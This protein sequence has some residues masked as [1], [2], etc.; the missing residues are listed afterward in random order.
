MQR[1]VETEIAQPFDLQQGPLLRVTLLRLA[2]DD[3]VLVLVQHHIVSDGWSMQLMVEELVQL[4]AAYSQGQ[5][6]QLPALPIQYADYAQWQRDWM[7]GGEKQRQLA[8]W[9]ALLGG[10]PSVLELPFDRPRPAVQSFRGARLEI[11]LAPAL[12]E[13]L[14]ALAQRE[15]VTLFIVLLASFQA[16]LHRYSGQEDIRVGVPIANRNRSETERLVGFFVN[17]QVL[18]ADFDA[19]LT[20]TQLLQQ[21]KHRA[22]DAQAHQDLP[23]EQLVEALQPE[24]SL[25]RNPLFQVLFNHQSQARLASTSQQLPDLRIESLEWGTQTAQ[26]DLD[27]DTQETVDG[28]WATLTYATDLFDAST[29]QSHGAPLAE[30]VAGHVG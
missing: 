12:V 5:D 8:Y 2:E 3:H 15:D 20:V 26:F 29:V 19:Q 28:L 14:K 4:Y 13:G 24:R 11:K 10:E 9:Q 1:R 18:K 16:L 27:L 22:L 7:T 30:P 25:S 21:A 23:F 17:T 6:V